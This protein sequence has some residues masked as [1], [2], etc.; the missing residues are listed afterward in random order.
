MGQ[1]P[2]SFE[3]PTPFFQGTIQIM[4]EKPKTTYQVFQSTDDNPDASGFSLI[5]ML[6]VM[7]II[8]VLLALSAPAWMSQQ[9]VDLKGASLRLAALFDAGRSQAISLG[10]P[11]R[12]LIHNDPSEP[13]F[14]L[15]RI[16]VVQRQDD[17]ISW[18]SVLHPMLLPAGVYF[19]RSQAGST[20]RVMEF[21][22]IAAGSAHSWLYYEILPNGSVTGEERNLVLGAGILT[23]PN[24]QPVFPNPDRSAGF[25]IS[26]SARLL[27]F[28]SPDDIVVNSP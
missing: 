8:G 16:D 21:R 28:R 4:A 26:D 13:E 15:R 23:P 6:I 18:N 5:E 25:R 17:E 19:D 24:V 14:Y 9:S 22:G 2:F 1:I 3:S 20:N 7:S 10:E 11:V 27:H 12:I